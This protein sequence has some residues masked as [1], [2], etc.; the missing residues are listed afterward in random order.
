M[1]R[2]DAY[3]NDLSKTDSFGNPRTALAPH[4][5]THVEVEEGSPEA[6]GLVLLTQH[7]GL[8]MTTSIRQL[9]SAYYR[10]HID[11]VRSQHLA[12]ALVALDRADIQTA[13]E[14]IARAIEER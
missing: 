7:T 2:L 1:P 5:D 11:N 14:A 4:A 12:E 13:K 9:L 6:A 10:Q 3:G 8:G